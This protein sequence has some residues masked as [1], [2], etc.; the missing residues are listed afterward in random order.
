MDCRSWWIWQIPMEALLPTGESFITYHWWSACCTTYD[1][2]VSLESSQ[3]PQG[4]V[5]NDLRFNLHKPESKFT[6]YNIEWNWCSQFGTPKALHKR[7]EQW[8]C[9]SNIGIAESS[10]IN[11]YNVIQH[12][13][14][15]DASSNSA[16]TVYVGAMSLLSTIKHVIRYRAIPETQYLISTLARRGRSQA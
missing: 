10:H 16:R 14:P 9:V 5:S 15:K 2:S 7:S 11:A 13:A 8:L 3:F 1:I 4:R 6:C 12:F